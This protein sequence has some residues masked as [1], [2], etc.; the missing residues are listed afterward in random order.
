MKE[1]E[2]NLNKLK[3]EKHGTVTNVFKMAEK[4]RGAK[5]QKEEAH[6]IKD[7]ETGKQLWPQKKSKE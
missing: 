4:I 7:P 5:K 2:D 3:S 6:A 1:I